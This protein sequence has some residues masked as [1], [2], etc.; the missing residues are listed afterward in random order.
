MPLIRA[1]IVDACKSDLSDGEDL[2]SLKTLILKSIDERLLMTNDIILATLFDLSAKS[3]VHQLS[4]D[5]K[6]Q[7][8]YKAIK[9]QAHKVA[10]QKKT[11][12]VS[13]D[14]SAALQLTA[15]ESTNTP[16]SSSSI[17]TGAT[18]SK[19]M[20]LV[21]KHGPHSEQPD[22]EIMEQIKNYL[23]YIPGSDDEDPLAF[24][25][26]GLF[27]TLE[28]A[29]KKYLTRSA[30]SVPAE[31]KFSLMGLL[32]NGKRSTLAPHCANW[33]SFIHDNYQLH[34]DAD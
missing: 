23:R 7:L 26:K 10:M 31:N 8:V 34:C 13:V 18:L 28:G 21:Q 12:S 22:S 17:V 3:L 16:V 24:W 29:A 6:E 32:V 15:T 4:D 27:P 33:L 19:K 25:K 9:E 20:K 2:K 11:S 14:A 5:G 30:S 1:E